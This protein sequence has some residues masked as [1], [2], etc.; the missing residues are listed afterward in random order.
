MAE[1]GIIGISGLCEHGMDAIMQT[2]YSRAINEGKAYPGQIEVY[3][4]DIRQIHK[5]SLLKRN[6]AKMRN[7]ALV[8]KTE[9]IAAHYHPNWNNCSTYAKKLLS[10]NAHIIFGYNLDRPV[11]AVITWCELDNFGQP[12]G[13]TATALKMAFDRQ[14][15]VFNLY[16][17]DKAETLDQISRFL[18]RKNIRIK[19]E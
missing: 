17:P 13:G 11:D 12:K 2:E 14:I 5:S 7:P 9:Q 1:L 19:A 10:R 16:L 6:L 8:A 18:K 15:P 3:V 4:A